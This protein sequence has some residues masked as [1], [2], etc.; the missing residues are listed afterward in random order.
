MKKRIYIVHGY[1]ANAFDHWF[2]FI[3]KSLE[4]TQVCVN[5]VQLPNSDNPNLSVWINCLKDNISNI[6]ENTLIIAHSLGCI[7]TL[8]FLQNENFISLGGLA[9]VSGFYERLDPI[10][11]LD[12]FIDETRKDFYFSNKIIKKI[13]FLSNNDSY[14]PPILS[15]RLAKKLNSPY[16]I[17]ES[18][19]HFLSADG[20]DEFIELLNWV[21]E[22]FIDC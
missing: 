7:S 4:N 3:K 22:E 11:E 2:S 21:K 17:M 20:Y 16:E 9:L 13:V 8:N 6:N 14:V 1:K 19:G 12:K 18:A 10:P 15:L 5:I